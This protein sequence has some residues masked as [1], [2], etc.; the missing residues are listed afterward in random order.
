M[1][2]IPPRSAFASRPAIST[3]PAPAADPDANLFPARSES[4]MRADAA[5][6]APRSTTG[7][8]VCHPIAPRLTMVAAARVARTLG[9]T[10]PLHV[11]RTP[12]RPGTHPLRLDPTLCDP[13]SR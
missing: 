6:G 8:A 13:Q 7:I 5:S 1:R 11:L 9:K 10:G 3:A 2:V 4:S 12:E